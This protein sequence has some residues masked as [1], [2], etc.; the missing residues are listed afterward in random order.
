MSK[1]LRLSVCLYTLSGTASG[2]LELPSPEIE[3]KEITSGGQ[4]V[5][6]SLGFTAAVR[7][8]VYRG[9]GPVGVTGSVG[10]WRKAS[11]LYGTFK[12]VGADLNGSN[13]DLFKVANGVLFDRD[14]NPT[15]QVSSAC[16]DP[17]HYC[18][19]VPSD[20]FLAIMES[21]ANSG[22]VRLAYNRRDGGM[23]VPIDLPVAPDVALKLLKCTER[24]VAPLPDGGASRP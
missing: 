19:A 14:G 16:E 24:L 17:L 5:A 9:G 4:L 13:A 20:A 3:A 18:A 22:G 12:I 15:K 8:H 10:L 2:A 6:C 21:I 11:K 7:D 23:D 1:L